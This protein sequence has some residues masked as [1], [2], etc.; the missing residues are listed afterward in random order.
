MTAMQVSVRKQLPQ[1]RKSLCT[2]KNAKPQYF[3]LTSGAISS[4]IPLDKTQNLGLNIEK[5]THSVVQMNVHKSLPVIGDVS[6]E[7][8]SNDVM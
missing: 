4:I 1:K 7:F 8:T 3:C 5:S 2:T 6:Q